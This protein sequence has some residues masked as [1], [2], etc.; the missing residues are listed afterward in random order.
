MKKLILL[1]SI[2]TLLCGCS[3]QDKPSFSPEKKNS[4]YYWQTTF[5]PDSADYA[6]IRRHNI[7]RIYLR[8]F[9]V[10]IHDYSHGS[11]PVPNATVRIPDKT[12]YNL[13]DSFS[14]IEFIPVV[15]ITL[16]ALKTVKG[17]EGTLAEKI[18]TRV[19]NMCSY[20]KLP[21]VKG[22]QLDCDWTASTEQ[23]FFSLCDSTNY[24]IRHAALDWKL[25]STIRLH[26]L[27]RK[28]PPTDYGVLMVYNTGNFNDP[29]VANSILDEKDVKP[30]LKYLNK[31]PL[32]LD[33]AY[34]AYSWQLLFHQRKF[35][36]ILNGVDLADT[37][38][39]KSNETHNTYQCMEDFPYRN[40]IIR[41]GD[42]VRSETSTY[43]DIQRV[44]K[45][46]DQELYNKQHSNVLYHFNLQN[47]SKYSD[48]EIQQILSFN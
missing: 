14:T 33:V 10:S 9:D 22:L 18:V 7:G 32:H 48:H 34:P 31:Y 23:S 19:K 40:I 42:L 16:D 1:I 36:G 2:L 39:F 6:F 24:Y 28:E 35:V 25:S 26:Q 27:A 44:K 29:D 37:T 46:I 45:L 47:L 30:Y 43:Q 13:K 3:I 5:S 20:N 38:I 41:K 8:M 15:Y 11:D 12:Y 21:N 4:V 17:Q